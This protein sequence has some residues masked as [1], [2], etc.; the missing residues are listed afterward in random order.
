MLI[1]PVDV[2]RLPVTRELYRSCNV[3]I[4]AITIRITD[5]VVIMIHDLGRDPVYVDKSL[6]RSQCMVAVVKRLKVL[7]TCC[8]LWVSGK[9][10]LSMFR[11]TRNLVFH[12]RIDVREYVPH[13]GQE[14]GHV[15]A[16]Q[17]YVLHILQ[18]LVVALIHESE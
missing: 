11:T 7:A 18:W 13:S 3:Y 6:I 16:L 9:P 14:Y 12:T 5:G 4:P 1:R 8:E 15:V 10:C 17:A 2:E